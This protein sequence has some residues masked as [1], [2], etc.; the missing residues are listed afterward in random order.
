MI[1]FTVITANV[2]VF[3]ITRKVMM[4]WHWLNFRLYLHIIIWVQ[5]KMNHSAMVKNQSRSLSKVKLSSLHVIFG[6]SVCNN[7]IRVCT[8][9]TCFLTSG[10]QGFYDMW[11]CGIV[12][13]PTIY[14][15]EQ[16]L[17]FGYSIW[18]YCNFANIWIN[19]LALLSEVILATIGNEGNFVA[20]M[21]PSEL[22]MIPLCPHKTR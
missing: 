13:C 22:S 7:S 1:W 4:I 21:C 6:L 14:Q 8:K 17:W 2:T 5:T 16:L 15:K 11:Q 3:V 12:I 9:K 18:P 10:E 20:V 19:C